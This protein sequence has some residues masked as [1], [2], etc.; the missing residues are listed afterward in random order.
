[1]V[2]AIQTDERAVAA[3]I[4]SVLECYFRLTFISAFGALLPSYCVTALSCRPV[5][6]GTP[7]MRIKSLVTGTKAVL[8]H[9]CCLLSV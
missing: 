5:A 1:M 3:G 8:E 9:W 7:W 2:R 4:L 6:C